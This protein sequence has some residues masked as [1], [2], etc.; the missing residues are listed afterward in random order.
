LSHQR[1]CPAIEIG[2][3][4]AST[5]ETRG[6]AAQ[7]N[8]AVPPITWCR[9]NGPYVVNQWSSARYVICGILGRGTGRHKVRR[10]DAS[11]LPKQPA[12]FEW[13]FPVGCRRIKRRLCDS[14]GSKCWKQLQDKRRY[15]NDGRNDGY[16]PKGFPFLD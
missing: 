9:R 14:S 4:A 5:N 10:R 8:R 7:N 15:G 11:S 6:N 16:R 1:K 3:S 13:H 2:Q 12:I